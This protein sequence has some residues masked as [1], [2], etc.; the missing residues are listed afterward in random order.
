VNVDFWDKLLHMKKVYRNIIDFL[1]D[2]RWKLGSS[3]HVRFRMYCAGFY[4]RYPFTEY[5]KLL[6]YMETAV[7]KEDFSFIIAR[8]HPKLLQEL[9][10]RLS[11]EWLALAVAIINDNP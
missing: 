6:E 5:S 4:T 10:P 8:M 1:R 7:S 2:T 11:I 9:L 3:A